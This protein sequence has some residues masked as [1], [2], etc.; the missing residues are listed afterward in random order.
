MKTLALAAAL[1]LSAGSASAG[2]L[3]FGATDLQDVSGGWGT[4]FSK[5]YHLHLD[6]GSWI[7]GELLT[8]SLFVGQPPTVDVQ[9]TLLRQGSTSVVWNETAAVDWDVTDAASEQWSLP[10]Q[11]FAAGDWELVVSGITYADKAGEGF[12]VT[13]RVPEPAT[14]GLVVLALAGVG[15]AQ[16]RRKAA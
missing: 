3:N 1:A 9:A 16:R 7:S 15:A 2:V 8:K 13:V 4:A 6:A 14:A 5:T 11:W 12:D 10:T